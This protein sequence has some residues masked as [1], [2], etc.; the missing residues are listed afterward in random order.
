[1]NT[2]LACAVTLV[3]LQDPIPAN[4]VPIPIPVRRFAAV[5]VSLHNADTVP[6]LIHLKRVEVISVDSHASQ[7][8]QEEFK[9]IRL[10]G[11]ES[12]TLDIFLSEDSPYNTTRS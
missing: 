9:S 12:R 7:F 11:G 2:K 6:Q 4:S 5:F 3:A 10:E 8:R 1:M